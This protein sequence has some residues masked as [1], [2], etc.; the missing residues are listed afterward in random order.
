V[1]ERL[2]PVVFQPSG[3]TVSVPSG[4]NLFSLMTELGLTHSATCGGK[5]K[6]GK[7]KVKV[8]TGVEAINA[9]TESEL[10]HL[11]PQ[12]IGQGYR[13]ACAISVPPVPSFTVRTSSIRQGKLKLQTEGALVSISPDPAVRKYVIRLIDSDLPAEEMLLALLKRKYALSCQMDYEVLTM[14]PAAIERGKGF[15]TCVVYQGNT[16]IAVE[17]G[18]TGR[19]CLGFAADIGTTKVAVYLMDLNSGKELSF[20]AAP[21]PQAIYGDDVMSRIAFS[22]AREGNTLILQKILLKEVAHLVRDCCTKARLKPR[23]I[24]EGCFVG[25]PCMMHLLLGFSPRSLAFFPYKSVSHHSVTLKARELPVRLHV[26]PAGRIFTLPLIA[27]FVGADTVAALIAVRQ[28]KPHGVQM[29]LDIGTNTEVVLSDEKGFMAC[30]CAS[31]PAFEGM[32]ITHGRKADSASIEKVSVDPETLEVTFQTI[33]GAKP[34][35]ICGSGIASAIAELLR[36]GVIGTNGKIRGELSRK[37]HRVRKV[38]ENFFE[39]VLAWK[40]ETDIGYDITV[41]QKDVLEV[42]KA[43]AAIYTGCTLLMRQKGI[44]ADQVQSMTIAG[45]FGQHVDKASVRAIGMFPDVPLDRIKEAGNAA[46]TGAKMALISRQKREEAAHVARSTKYY[47]LA[48]D[49]DFTREYATSMLFPRQ[50]S[51]MINSV[52][53]KVESKNAHR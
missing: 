43:K 49:E 16:V 2:I 25:N 28:N 7:C 29:L 36:V 26:H 45:A 32:H 53:E 27:G 20:S 30:S 35:G 3:K 37:T 38:R 12:E 47:E 8:E 52:E 31:G 22:M 10:K 44:T 51:P 15:V 13:L 41:S 9:S 48:L 5:G 1:S 14:L 46:G 50:P 40:H 11:L 4:T 42:Q 33:D 21:N 39:F 18:D 34:A 24:Y 17:P 23:S 6:C 19:D